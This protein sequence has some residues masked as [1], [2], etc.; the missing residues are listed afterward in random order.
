MDVAST[1]GAGSVHQTWDYDDHEDAVEWLWAA[2]WWGMIPAAIIAG[3]T[4]FL[5]V[6]HVLTGRRS[7][8][9]R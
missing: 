4:A 9:L 6:I 7:G 2:A 5:V 3:L 8:E 1:G